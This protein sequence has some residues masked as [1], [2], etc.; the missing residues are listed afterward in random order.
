MSLFLA[1]S[2]QRFR[3]ELKVKENFILS[4][5]IYKKAHFMMAQTEKKVAQ[6][7]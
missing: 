6:I 7:M 1:E 3:S 5:K 2:T 4:S